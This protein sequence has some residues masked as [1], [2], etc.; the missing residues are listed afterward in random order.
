MTYVSLISG[1]AFGNCAGPVDELSSAG[2]PS[3]FMISAAA[4]AGGGLGMATPD[5]D[6]AAAV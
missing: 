6:G 1:T 3:E 2:T 4:E 5:G